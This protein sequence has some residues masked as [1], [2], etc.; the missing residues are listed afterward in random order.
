[1]FCEKSKKVFQHERNTGE[2]QRRLQQIYY[3]YYSTP[4]RRSLGN[5]SA[6]KK[7]KKNL[8][9]DKRQSCSCFHFTLEFHSE[10]EANSVTNDF[11]RLCKN[12]TNFDE[13]FSFLFFVQKK[14]QLPQYC[15]TSVFQMIWN[16]FCSRLRDWTNLCAKSQQI[17]FLE[18]FRKCPKG[19]FHFFRLK[20]Y[21]LNSDLKFFFLHNRS[22]SANNHN[23]DENLNWNLKHFFFN[24]QS[25]SHSDSPHLSLKGSLKNVKNRTACNGKGKSGGRKTAPN[26]DARDRRRV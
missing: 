2:K 6:V 20:F 17:F 16:S 12:G 9:T 18:I 26:T 10:N 21:W 23:S 14:E 5:A 4:V 25:T 24:F 13:E 15:Y 22:R 11:F 8:L 7:V 19:W 1:V 3:Y